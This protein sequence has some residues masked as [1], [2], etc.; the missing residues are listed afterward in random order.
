MKNTE[1]LRHAIQNEEEV[2]IVQEIEE[3]PNVYNFY[4]QMDGFVEEVYGYLKKGWF[5]TIKESTVQEVQESRS[6]F[7][8]QV[9]EIAFENVMKHVLECGWPFPEDIRERITEATLLD[10]IGEAA[11]TIIKS[12]EVLVIQDLKKKS[13]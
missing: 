7:D 4:V 6:G 11:L 12:M 2:V 13:P 5:D 8:G 10:S 3:R 9:L 1:S